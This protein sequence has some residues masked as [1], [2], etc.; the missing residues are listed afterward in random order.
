MDFKKRDINLS[1]KLCK[2]YFVQLAILHQWYKCLPVL[3]RY[4][5][6]GCS[7]CGRA[8][9]L[10]ESSTDLQEKAYLAENGL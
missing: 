7:E 5:T 10:I 3:L 2:Y 9:W 1:G 4:E 8:W 6:A